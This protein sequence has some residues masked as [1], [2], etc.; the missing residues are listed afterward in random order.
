[1]ENDALTPTAQDLIDEIGAAFVSRTEPPPNSFTLAD[2]IAL[3]GGKAQDDKV[4]LIEKQAANGVQS[5]AFV[6]YLKAFFEQRRP[7]PL[8]G[9]LVIVDHQNLRCH[10]R[11]SLSF[12]LVPAS[13]ERFPQP[14]VA[15]RPKR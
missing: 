14:G 10:R 11:F 6:L 5:N 15:Q 12:D 1:M 4:R 3:K 13:S 2:F 9:C 7:E 8:Y